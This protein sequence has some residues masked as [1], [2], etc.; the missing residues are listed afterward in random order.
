MKTTYSV[1]IPVAFEIV[2]DDEYEA[3]D[4]AY[5]TFSFR[6]KDIERYSI[7]VQDHE[8]RMQELKEEEDEEAEEEAE[9]EAD[10]QT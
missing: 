9:E 1:V 4:T 8:A 3:V 10:A 2:A 5:E 7:E 6:F